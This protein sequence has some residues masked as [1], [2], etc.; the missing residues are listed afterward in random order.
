MTLAENI[1]IERKEEFQ[2]REIVRSI[3]QEGGVQRAMDILAKQYP[4]TVR[5]YHIHHGA[6]GMAWGVKTFYFSIANEKGF[7]R[8]ADDM[9][10][11]QR[12]KRFPVPLG[13]RNPGITFFQV[14]CVQFM[15]HNPAAYFFSYFFR[16]ACVIIVAMG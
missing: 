1:D 14:H 10:H 12:L 5:F 13:P 3:G 4:F 16:A 2:R 8:A 11:P 7:F 15:R 6:G 9:I